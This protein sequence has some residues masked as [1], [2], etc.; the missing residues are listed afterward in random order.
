MRRN[1]SHNGAR[2]EGGSTRMKQIPSTCPY[3]GVGCGI[4]LNVDDADRIRWVDDVPS[5]PSSDGML[6]VK[7]RFGTTFVNHPIA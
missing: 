1:V 2:A 3:C 5:N 7:G 6:C 4:V